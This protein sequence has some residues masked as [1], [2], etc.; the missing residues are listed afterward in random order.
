MWKKLFADGTEICEPSSWSRTSLDNVIG[1]TLNHKDCNVAIYGVGNYWQS[2]TYINNLNWG[3]S[4]SRLVKRRIS[5]YLDNISVG[6]I[7]IN[8][9]NNFKINFD[10]VVNAHKDP[11][12]LVLYNDVPTWF[13]VEIDVIKENVLCYLSK[14]RI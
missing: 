11:P 7:I 1:V 14:D 12:N 10:V 6:Q 4:G 13:I 8:D 9:Q 2:D 5:K 3:I